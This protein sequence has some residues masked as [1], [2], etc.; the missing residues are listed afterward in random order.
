MAKLTDKQRKKIIAEYIAGDGKVTQAQLAEKYGVTRQAISLV[1]S[2]EKTCEALR[3]KKKDNELSMLAFLDERSEKAQ[4]LID[5]ILDTLPQDFEKASMRDKAGLLKILS[6]VFSGK[7]N[8]EQGRES[9]QPKF[10]FVFSD[11]SVKDIDD[12]Q[13]KDNT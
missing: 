8:G 7:G 10:E 6:E 1:L 11:V 2:D 12:V 5:K 4:S 3:N 9:I 13:K